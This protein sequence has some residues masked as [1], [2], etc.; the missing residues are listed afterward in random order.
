M[1]YQWH[2]VF[3]IRLLRHIALA[4]TLTNRRILQWRHHRAAACV[5]GTSTAS[6]STAATMTGGERSTRHKGL[7]I[8]TALT[9][10]EQT[11]SEIL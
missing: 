5:M 11:Q 10:K 1:K 2:G 7:L 8:F 4:K 3:I 9:Y 6:S